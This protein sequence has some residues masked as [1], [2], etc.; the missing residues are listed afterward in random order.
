MTKV[1][2]SY[3]WMLADFIILRY[4]GEVLDFDVERKN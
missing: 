2:I 1:I 3:R 4:L